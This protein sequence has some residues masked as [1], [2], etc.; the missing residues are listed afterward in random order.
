MTKDELKLLV[1]GFKKGTLSEE[2]LLARVTSLEPESL[3][4]A[5]IDHH[6]QLRQGFPEVILCQG[7]TPAQVGEIAARIAMRKEPLLATR[8]DKDHFKAVKKRVPSND[9]RPQN[10]K[11]RVI[12][13]PRATL[14]RHASDAS[15]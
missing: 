14:A 4:F 5:T 1:R 11:F 2:E 15:K 3:G 7:K 13:E 6:R 9:R 12:S 8:A 10:K